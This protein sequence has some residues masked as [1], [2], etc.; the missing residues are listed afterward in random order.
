MT[1]QKFLINSSNIGVELWQDTNYSD[2]W[3]DTHCLIQ[4]PW[5]LHLQNHAVH[6]I[7]DIV[8]EDCNYKGNQQLSLSAKGHH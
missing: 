6:W 3:K 2:E 1:K 4:Q 8:K 5:T 7:I